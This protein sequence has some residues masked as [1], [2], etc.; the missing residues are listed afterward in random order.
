MTS[1]PHVYAR[2][3]S[4]ILGPIVLLAVLFGGGAPEQSAASVI[5]HAK[6]QAARRPVRVIPA[7][8]P[9]GAPAPKPK[10]TPAP[11]PQSKATQKKASGGSASVFGGLGA[12]VDLFDL[13]AL[14]AGPT[15]AMMKRNGVRTLYLQ[16]GRSDTRYAVQPGVIP[17]LVA[18]QDAGLKVV[19]WYLPYYVGVNYDVSRVVSIARFRY[20]THRF[21]GVGVDIEFKGAQPNN[22]K[23]NRNVAGEMKMVRAILGPDYPLA[24]IPPPPLQMRLAP[25]FW[26]G[27]PWKALGRYSSEIMLMAYWS[28][29]TGC[30]KIRIH[31][32]YE[33][34]KYN[35]LKTR[36][37][38]GSQVPIHIIGGVADG[39]STGQLKRF[40]RG[41]IDAH[42][43]G[44]SIYDVAT[45][46]RA[47]WREL[48]KLTILGS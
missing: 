35:I 16:T 5:T 44:A 22:A 11:Q 20:G 43:N 33:Y 37:L 48:R 12:W 28:P 46:K 18:A 2:I 31:C 17:W 7:E 25:T 23:W 3:C 9:D 30:P 42:A 15:V 26:R 38:A 39:I 10:P 36:E 47:W 40:I 24:S 6:K 13:D 21:D 29:R 34:T 4:S 27:F 32:A 41:A 19:G 8:R 45:T 1:S 14:A